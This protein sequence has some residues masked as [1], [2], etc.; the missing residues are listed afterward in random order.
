MASRILGCIYLRFILLNDPETAQR[1]RALDFAGLTRA[2]PNASIFAIR[3]SDREE[4]ELSP[5][6]AKKS[7]RILTQESYINKRQKLS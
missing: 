5:F 2:L 6:Q 3:R 4:Y 7:E 1:S